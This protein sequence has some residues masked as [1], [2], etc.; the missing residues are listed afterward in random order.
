MSISYTNNS[1][2]NKEFA[3]NTL[4]EN[5]KNE[6]IIKI[7]EQ[8]DKNPNML[9]EII[10]SNSFLIIGVSNKTEISD[11]QSFREAMGDM[12][13]NCIA[14]IFVSRKKSIF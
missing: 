1:Y 6:V 11:L 5:E 8:A 3:A 7:V 13:K 12:M 10:N 14:G 9:K 2:K 4:V